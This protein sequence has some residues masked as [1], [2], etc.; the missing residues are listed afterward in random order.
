MLIADLR[1]AHQRVLVRDRDR[2]AGCLGQQL[3][4]AAAVHRDEPPHRLVDGPADGQQPVIAQDDRL[5]L[6]ERLRDAVA[7]RGLVDDAGVV[8]EHARGP[9]KT[10]RRPA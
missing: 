9:R 7:L 8:V 5:A 4:V 3:R 1:R 6:A 2:L 10:R